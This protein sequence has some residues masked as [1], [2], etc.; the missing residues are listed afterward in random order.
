MMS[1]LA[2]VALC[3]GGV[4][5][6]K[7][8]W[9]MAAPR[10]AAACARRFPR[11]VW[12]GRLLAAAAVAWSAK[13]LFQTGFSWVESHRL[14]VLLAVPVAYAVVILCVDELLAVRAGGGLLLLVPQVILDAAFTH[15]ARSR[16]VMTGFAYLLVAAGIAL[17]WSPYLF[18]RWTEQ[19]LDRAPAV[20]AAGAGLL[21]L[22]LAM[23]AL[24][25]RVY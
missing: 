18:R 23:L 4:L 14:L 15:P 9:L 7:G 2:L 19:W 24:G 8:L 10:S 11:H 3:V 12:A 16:L 22:G 25:L 1:R 21:A 13:L 6:L 5:S 20:R 17:V